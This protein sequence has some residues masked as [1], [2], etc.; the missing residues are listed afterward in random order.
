MAVICRVGE[1]INRDGIRQK[2]SVSKTSLH[3]TRR[4]E[5]VVNEYRQSRQ[6]MLG[7]LKEATHHNV[8]EL[9]K[10]VSTDLVEPW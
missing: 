10:S 9:Y 3:N 2:K 4:I 1:G 7:R 6:V 8:Q 5:E